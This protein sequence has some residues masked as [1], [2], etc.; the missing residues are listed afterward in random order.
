MGKR[1]RAPSSSRDNHRKPPQSARHVCTHSEEDW[2]DLLLRL[3]DSPE[4]WFLLLDDER[5]PGFEEVAWFI[6]EHNW[7]DPVRMNTLRSQLDRLVDLEHAALRL[8]QSDN[9]A[10]HEFADP[11]P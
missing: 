7:R 1:T 6:G 8:V 10:H 3:E 5:P 2:H 9:G 11:T 4:P